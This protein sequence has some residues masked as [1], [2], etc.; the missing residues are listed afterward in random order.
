MRAISRTQIL[1]ETIYNNPDS[2][3]CYPLSR[4]VVRWIY[5]REIREPIFRIAWNSSLQ[6]T[7]LELHRHLSDLWTYVGMFYA[8][9]L[10]S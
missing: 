4:L 8:V 10:L 7:S 9:G 1:Y 5:A 3:R 6:L 2:P